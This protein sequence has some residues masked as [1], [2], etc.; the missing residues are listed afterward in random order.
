MI[1]SFA[2][3]LAKLNYSEFETQIQNIATYTFNQWYDTYYKDHLSDYPNADY[4]AD[5]FIK[6]ANGLPADPIYEGFVYYDSHRNTIAGIITLNRDELA[7]YKSDMFVCIN[8]V[9]VLPEYRG[10]GIAKKLIKFLMVRTLYTKTYLKQINLFC[11]KHLIDF[12]K[13]MGWT[14]ISETPQ[15][16]YWYEMVWSFNIQNNHIYCE[17]NSFI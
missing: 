2:E 6:I 11:E 10:Q 4:I 7:P 1:I 5:N 17:Q 14:L 12:Y 16:K 3:A 13:S 15:F 9:F 8:N